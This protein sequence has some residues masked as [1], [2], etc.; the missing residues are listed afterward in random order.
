ML[1]VREIKL[2][3]DIDSADNLRLKILKKLRLPKDCNLTYKIVKKSIDARKKPYVYYVYE[4][5][6]NLDKNLEESLLKVNN[7]DIV[8]GKEVK[9][10]F[11]PQGIIPLKKPII[12]VGS[13][14]AG[15]FASLNLVRNAIKLLLLNAVVKLKKELLK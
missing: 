12:V 13:G 1:R 3:Y 2:E 14:P 6:C 8:M 4:V 7:K 11:R 9:Y 15:L 10:E 5:L